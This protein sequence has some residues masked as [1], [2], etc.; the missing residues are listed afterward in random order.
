MAGLLAVTP[1]TYAPIERPRGDRRI[2][3]CSEATTSSA[4]IELP[5]WNRASVRN[6]ML[7][8]LPSADSSGNAAART[9]KKCRLGSKMYSVSWIC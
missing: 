9:G 2:Q 1:S 6:L 4:T 8:C 7:Y 5:S 3:R